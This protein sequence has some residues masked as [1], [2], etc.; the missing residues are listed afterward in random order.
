MKTRSAITVLFVL[1]LAAIAPENAAAEEV[2]SAPAQAVEPWSPWAESKLG[3][4]FQIDGYFWT[5]TGYLDR[6]NTQSGAYDSGQNYMGGRLVVGASYQRALGEY[7]AKAR[8]QYLGL[9]NE[10]TNTSYEPH[11]LDAYLQVGSKLWDLQLG[12]F[13]ASEVYYR[14]QGIELYTA[15]EAGALGGPSMYLLDLTRGHKNEAGQAAFH[16]RPAS[17]LSFE[18]GSVYG[19]ENNQNKRGV[20]PVVDFSLAGLK[21][22]GGYEYFAERP[23]DDSNKVEATSKGYGGRMQYSFAR[24]GS[25]WLRAPAWVSYSEEAG[26]GWTGPVATFGVDFAAVTVDATDINGLVDAE[27]TFDKTTVGAFADLDFWK[28]SLGAAYHQTTQENEQGEEIVQHQLSVSY[29]YRLPIPGLSVKAVYGFARAELE[30]VDTGAEWEND[31][32]SFRV[33]LRY[34]FM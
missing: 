30:D 22:I 29:L 19:R 26:K 1:A 20:R 21:L 31:L 24:Q 2:A 12:R 4:P 25:A 27:K 18:V 14:G 15:E 23:L 16:L 33:R 9:E 3:V 8:V 7:F 13:L 10:F 28:N 17:F 11:T 32:Q 34:D 6:N 5:D